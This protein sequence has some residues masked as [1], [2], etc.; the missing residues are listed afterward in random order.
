M[1][2]GEEQASVM[3]MVTLSEAYA[4]TSPGMRDQLIVRIAVAPL[5]IGP[6]SWRVLTASPDRCCLRRWHASRRTAPAGG[7]EC[8]RRP[9]DH[10]RRDAAVRP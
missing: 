1:A 4:K 5:E 6:I 9:A 8:L 10:R 7:S 3:S 2:I